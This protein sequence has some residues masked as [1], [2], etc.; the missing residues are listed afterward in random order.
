MRIAGRAPGVVQ[1]STYNVIIRFPHVETNYNQI[2]RQT[3]AG[4]TAEFLSS[5]FQLL[6]T[7]LADGR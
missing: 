4:P 3:A 5:S 6:V 1:L 7:E 2:R